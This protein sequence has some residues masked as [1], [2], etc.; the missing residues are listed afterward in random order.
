MAPP[1][2]AVRAETA[3]ASGTGGTGRGGLRAA[4]NDMVVTTTHT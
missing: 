4:L 1:L 3:G 2:G